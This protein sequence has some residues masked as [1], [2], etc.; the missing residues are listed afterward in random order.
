MSTC[1]L[2][3][4]DTGTT[5]LMERVGYLFHTLSDHFSS[6]FD[7]TDRG[8]DEVREEADGDS[9]GGKTGIASSRTP[10]C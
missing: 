1:V 10:P 9:D 6:L 7:Q 2:F 5:I 4:F 3:L 8:R